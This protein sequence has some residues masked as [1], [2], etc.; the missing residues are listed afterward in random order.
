MRADA[1]GRQ[2][3]AG[4]VMGFLAAAGRG[5]YAGAAR[6]L[7]TRLPPAK[8]QELAQQLKVVLDR[9]LTVDL[10]H[11]SRKP[12][13]DQDA[14]AGKDREVV[15]TI[16]GET[17]DLRIVLERVRFA[18]EPPIWLFSSETLRRVPEFHEAYAPS[19]L[20]RY[21]PA[22][23]R[24]GSGFRFG[25]V[26]WLV[27]LILCCA[28]FGVARL[29]A[30]LS[31]VVVRPLL[32]RLS[33]EEV[34]RRW[35]SLVTPLQ[36]LLFGIGVRALAGSLF[37]LRQRYLV[38]RLATLIIITG[39]AW[40]VIRTTVTVVTRWTHSMERFGRTER[41]ALI[42]LA[43]RLFQAAVVFGC[44]LVLLGR[45]GVDITPVLA[46][47]GVGGI[48]VA[49]ASQKTLENLFGG[50]MV[51][52]D[53]PIRIGNFCRVGTM[54]GTVEDIGLRSTRIRTLNRT[55]ISVPNAELASTSL[56]NFAVRDKMLFNHTVSLR[57]ETTA[58][59]LR[60]VLEGSRALLHAHPL[61]E[62]ATVRVRL[63][64]FAPS[65]MDFELFAYVR[66][67]DYE[68]FLA[69]QE[70]LLL[71]LLDVIKACGTEMARPSQWAPS[72]DAGPRAG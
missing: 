34:K 58:D 14:R 69:T 67:Q 56:E 48:A 9:G 10:D 42:R 35:L 18:D 57:H 8:A 15:G 46:G 68:L 53:S 17:A 7:D 11:L 29:V 22:L 1:L 19:A 32:R 6:Y 70:E 21:L 27:A 26:G 37:T 44:M 72:A 51:I 66:T 30:G 64:R 12:E 41:V 65:G 71:G 28:A 31:G 63:L 49:L 4:T 62:P 52:G 61:I 43:G 2:T 38:G 25:L 3:P 13:G 33:D 20:E 59:Q 55:V 47:L 23:G 60:A 54:T 24:E 5:D 39:I 36:W 16:D 40:F 45:V 50:M